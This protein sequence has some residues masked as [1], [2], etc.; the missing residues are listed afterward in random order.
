MKKV[1]CTAFAGILWLFFSCDIAPEQIHYGTDACSFC[2][3]TIVDQKHASQYVTKKGK[4]FKFD[5]IECMV[6]DIAENG[7]EGIG[8]LLVADF[9]NPGNMVEAGGASYLIS[10]TIKSPMGANLSGFA[11]REAARTTQNESGGKV[12]SWEELLHKF[13]AE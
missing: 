10:E 5:A 6:N 12:Y 2:K 4:Q 11:S 7:Q 9:Q 3:M 8:I 13:D 1:F